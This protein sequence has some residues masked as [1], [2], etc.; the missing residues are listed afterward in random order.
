MNDILSQWP[1]SNLVDVEFEG[2]VSTVQQDWLIQKMMINR[3]QCC[4]VCKYLIWN[5]VLITIW[6]LTGLCCA[7]KCSQ[8]YSDI[9]LVK[10]IFQVRRCSEWART[11]L[12]HVEYADLTHMTDTCKHLHCKYSHWSLNICGSLWCMPWFTA[13][14]IRMCGKSSDSTWPFSQVL[15][16]HCWACEGELVL[17]SNCDMEEQKKQKKKQCKTMQNW[18]KECSF[19]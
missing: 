3:F 7:C 1:L 16:V 17:L 10:T 14:S 19:R 4:C 15:V 18:K 13:T 11:A 8:Q 2:T 9:H 6:T 12:K 5:V